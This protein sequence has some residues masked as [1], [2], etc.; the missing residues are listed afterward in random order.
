LSF[1]Q[2]EAVVRAAST[3]MTVTRSPIAGESTQDR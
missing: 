1:P 2:S 3:P